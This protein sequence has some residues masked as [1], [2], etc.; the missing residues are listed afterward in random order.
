MKMVIAF[1]HR[2]IDAAERLAARIEDMGHDFEM[3]GPPRGS[4]CDY[5]GIAL[6]ACR[7]VVA[8]KA[9]LAVLIDAS[10]L[11]MAIA[12]NKVHGIRAAVVHDEMTAKIARTHL[13]ANALCMSADL[14]S[15]ATMERILGWFVEMAFEGGRHARRI[16]KIALIE[17]GQSPSSGIERG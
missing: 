4:A 1:D 7:R 6:D 17:Q 2:G 8:G 10:G 12:A 5:P 9:E 14:T 15:H 3:C 16:E 13:D 11:G